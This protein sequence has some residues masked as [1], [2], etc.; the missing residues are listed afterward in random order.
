MGGRGEG[1]RPATF[2]V[3]ACVPRAILVSFGASGSG[4]RPARHLGLLGAGA[5]GLSLVVGEVDL[6]VNGIERAEPR[7][8]MDRIV[9]APFPEV[10]QSCPAQLHFM[11][12]R[13]A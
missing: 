6:V 9:H 11:R 10:G 5:L 3:A 2:S 7:S 8:E 13:K 12:C 1:T 4:V